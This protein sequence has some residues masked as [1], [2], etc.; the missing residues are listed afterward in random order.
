MKALVRGNARHQR[1][2]G[3]AALYLA[4]A[5]L[6]AM[7]YFLIAVD[8]LSGPTPPRRSLCLQSTKAA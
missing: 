2:G 6:I 7:P 8:Y 5:Y 3:L 4:L 1:A